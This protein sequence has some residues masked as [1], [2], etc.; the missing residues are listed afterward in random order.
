MID[1]SNEVPWLGTAGSR[2]MAGVEALNRM[3]AESGF[4][5]HNGVT[6]TVYR[7]ST[8]SELDWQYLALRSA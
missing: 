4:F 5:K 2:G 1:L 6:I 8:Q 7:N 3:N